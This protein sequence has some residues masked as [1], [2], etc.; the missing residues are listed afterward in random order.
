MCAIFCPLFDIGVEEFP[1]IE[2]VHWVGKS[3]ITKADRSRDIIVRFRF[4]EDKAKIWVKLRGKAPLQHEGSEIQVFA[5]LAPETLARRRL[6]KPLLERMRTQNV[7]YSW[8]FTTCLLCFKEG[9]T[10]RLRFHEEL[11]D[12]C[13]R[14]RGGNWMGGWEVTSSTVLKRWVNPRYRQEKRV[15]HR[16][17]GIKK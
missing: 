8:G 5:D 6:L 9:R 16:K 17:V 12:F 3:D 2:K 7:K 15:P 10:A 11:G 1:N 14:K 4:Y 13:K